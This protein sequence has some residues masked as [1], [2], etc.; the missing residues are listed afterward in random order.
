MGQMR[1]RSIFLMILLFIISLGHSQTKNLS[2]LGEDDANE[3]FQHKNYLMAI[4]IYRKELKKYPD[5]DQ[6]RYK[7][8]KCLLYTRINRQEAVQHLE[9]LVNKN[10]KYDEA[11]KELGK[12]YH[13][14]N[15]LE[16]AE[17]A[18]NKYLELKPKK[19]T[20]VRY[21][22]KQ[23]ANARVY[24]NNPVNVTFQNLGQ[25]INSDEPDYYPFV[26]NTETFLG[27]TSRRKENVGGKKVEMDGYRSSDVYFSKIEDGNG[28]WIKPVNAGKLINTG[29]D[30][31][32]VGLKKDASELVIYIDHIDKY[33]DLYTT[34]SKPD[35]KSGATAASGPNFPYQK[36]KLIDPIINEKIETSGSFSEDGSVF[37][38]TRRDKFQEG[39]N[40]LFM[41]RRLPSGKWAPA[42]KLPPTINTEYNE[43]FPFLSEDCQTLYF[44][45]EGHNSM[46]GYD[47]F[48]TVWNPEDN[49]FSKPEN[50]GYPIN[51]TD[52][53]RSICVTPDNRVGYISAFRPGGY[54]DLDIYRIKFNETDQIIR[55]L[56]GQLWLG[57]SIPEHQPKEIISSIIATNKTTNQ[58]FTFVPHHKTGRF[59]M[60]LPAGKYSILV[61]ANGYKDLKEEMEISDFGRIEIEKE[62]DYLL[63]KK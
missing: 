29:F 44:A 18:Y 63:N 46:G 58:E 40:D 4:P 42:Q 62:K 1:T 5:N 7:L 16:K 20:E 24:M 9:K 45:S 30:E 36:I 32:I 3:H 37:F 53:D 59:V 33:G 43:D 39:N 6:M 34:T 61:N 25:E 10:D 8:A 49:S 17:G 55:I 19:E 48:R 52:D 14:T 28:K 12:A 56:I 26:N 50:L 15:Q 27:F 2:K 57:D 23:I 47:L 38:F 51:S 31:Q 41:V 11:W 54:G 60:S 13:L 22:L 35:V 21:F